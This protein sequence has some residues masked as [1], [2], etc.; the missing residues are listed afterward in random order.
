MNEPVE[1]PALNPWWGIWVQ[2]RQTLRTIVDT[3]PKMHFWVLVAFYGLMRAVSWGVQIGL[4]N[5]FSPAGVAGFILIMGPIAGIFGVYLTG[6]LLGLLGRSMG[7]KATPQQ[8]RTVLAWGAMPMSVLA[9]LALLPYVFMLGPLIFSTADPLVAQIMQG[10]GIPSRI[11]GDGLSV[12]RTIL[13]LTGSFYYIWIVVVGYAEVQK[14]HVVKSIGIFFIVMG[15]LVL[16]GL[17]FALIGT[18]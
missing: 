11:Q 1:S 10:Q 13:E 3:D 18:L 6:A 8:I 2:P 15:G 16:L 14:I 17:C 9:L 4:G 7:G 12:W 5:I